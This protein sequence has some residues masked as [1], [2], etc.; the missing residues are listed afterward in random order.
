MYNKK[1]V[2]YMY[3]YKYLHCHFGNKHVFFSDLSPY[4]NLTQVFYYWGMTRVS[5]TCQIRGRV[6][7]A[8][9]DCMMHINTLYTHSIRQVCARAYV[10]MCACVCVYVCAC[11]HACVCVCVRVCVYECVCVC[12]HVSVHI[13]NDPL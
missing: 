13:T 3:T 6:A 1:N 2:K 5:M 7:I 4:P 11:V 8:T 12:A 10:C 9:K